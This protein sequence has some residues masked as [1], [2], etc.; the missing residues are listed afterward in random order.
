MLP[1]YI[2]AYAMNNNSFL[3]LLMSYHLSHNHQRILHS[4]SSSHTYIKI[5]PHRNCTLVVFLEKIGP[6]NIC[7]INTQKGFIENFR[8]TEQEFETR[9]CAIETL[10]D[11]Q[12]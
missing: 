1:V 8:K 5:F 12:H 6:F 10:T 3:F 2:C 11:T 4:E 7:F 9:I